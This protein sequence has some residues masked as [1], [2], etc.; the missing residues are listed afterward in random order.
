MEI[1]CLNCKQAL[2]LCRAGTAVC[3][4]MGWTHVTTD[5]H[6]CDYDRERGRL[7]NRLA[8]PPPGRRIRLRELRLA[9]TAD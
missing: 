7:G 3:A 8:L 1:R 5:S 9:G 2:R 4:G 6:F